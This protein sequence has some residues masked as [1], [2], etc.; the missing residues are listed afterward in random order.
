M[1]IPVPAPVPA[2]PA[3]TAGEHAD[4]ITTDIPAFYRAFDAA[5]RKRAFR[6]YRAEGTEGLKAFFRIRIGSPRKLYDAVEQME[7]FYASIRPR[8]LAMHEN[9]RIERRIRAAIE[10]ASR[11][12]EDPRHLPITLVVGRASTAGTLTDRGLYLGAEFFTRGPDT[13]LGTT[14]RWFTSVVKPLSALPNTAV[15]EWLHAQQQHCVATTLLASSLQE[16]VADF[17]AHRY[18]PLD[19]PKG[20]TLWGEANEDDA[21]GEFQSVMHE[22]SLLG[23]L[24]S[25][26]ED[27]PADV[28]YFL[29][30]RIAEH[31][32]EAH[33]ELPVGERT[34]ALLSAHCDAPGFLEA[35]GY[36]D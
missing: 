20:Y 36:A 4:L 29:G 6:R 15:H 10:R 22:R 25:G 21:W 32:W 16:G 26:A 23:W 34:A 27:R 33:A 30:S 11:E 1:P 31:W 19:Q 13:E 7:P 9:P 12:I 18:A 24:Y 28:G 35:S 14:G 3:S 8:L 5:D 2:S 17:L